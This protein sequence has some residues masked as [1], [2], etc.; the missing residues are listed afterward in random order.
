[1]TW[2]FTDMAAPPGDGPG[3][4]FGLMPQAYP[5]GLRLTLTAEDMA[6]L[7]FEPDDAPEVGDMLHFAAM[8]KVV[9]CHQNETEAGVD[10][11]I[12]LQIVMM[13]VVENE[14][15]EFPDE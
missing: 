4:M 10:C 3:E 11:R 7:A 13:S 9:E 12:E 5:Y 8:A 15:A 6:R 14:S 2:K 1:M